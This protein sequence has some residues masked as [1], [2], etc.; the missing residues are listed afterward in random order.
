[1]SISGLVIHT[2][3]ENTECAKSALAELD[4]IE[5][6]A[7]TLDGRLIVTLDQP[8]DA[9]AAE[10]LSRLHELDGVLSASL[11]YNYFEQDPAEK[12]HAP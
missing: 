10:T 6:H 11:V 8:D 4:G 12:E 3:P 1:V 7:T 5:I 9:K 2:R